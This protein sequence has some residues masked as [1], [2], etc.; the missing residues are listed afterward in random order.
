MLG[1]FRVFHVE[2]GYEVYWCPSAPLHYED[3]IPA[4]SGK[5]YTKKQAAYASKDRLKKKLEERLRSAKPEES[6]A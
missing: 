4:N 2:D 3:K 5:V 1:E 6:A